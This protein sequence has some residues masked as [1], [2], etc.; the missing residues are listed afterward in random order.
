M[1]VSIIIGTENTVKL[2]FSTRARTV[3]LHTN[4]HR[5]RF[6][7]VAS[8]RFHNRWPGLVDLWKHFHGTMTYQRR[9]YILKAPNL[10][11]EC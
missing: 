11:I 3:N 1:S 9:T 8:S 2:H 10:R 6:S 7:S 4:N 5:F